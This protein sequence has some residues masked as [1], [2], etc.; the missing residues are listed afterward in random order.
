LTQFFDVSTGGNAAF[1]TADGGLVDISGLTSTGMTAGSIAGAGTYSLGS[2]ELTVGSNNSSTDVSGLI[3]GNGGSLVKVGTGTLTL[4]GDN[5]YSG[6]T[7]IQEGVL[8]AGTLNAAQ[9]IS[10]ALGTGNVFLDPGTLRTTSS[11]TGV[12][13]TINVGSNYTQAP[14]VRWRSESQALM[15]TNTIMCRL[16]VVRLWAGRWP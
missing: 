2:K 4:L 11:S 9:G 1:I 10:N 8:V 5:T 12:P 15:G 13:L 3:E 14:G 7:T 6:G 16:A